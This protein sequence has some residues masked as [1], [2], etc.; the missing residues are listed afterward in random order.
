[1]SKVDLHMHTVFSD[2]TDT[3]EELFACV[4]EAGITCFAIT[5]H[6]SIKSSRFMTEY[7]SETASPSIN[8][9]AGVEFSCKDELGKYHILGY[10]YDPDGD[11]IHS[12]VDKGHQLRM[13]KLNERIRLLK[14]QYAVAFTEEEIATLQNL[15]NP[16]KPHLA[17]LM[18]RNG[19]APNKRVAFSKYL[20]KIHASSEYIRPE[21]AIEGIVR[22]GGIAVLAH[23]SLGSGDESIEGDELVARVLRLK[24]MG[25]CGVEAFYS[26][27]DENRT[28]E[29]LD[30]AKRHSLYVTAGSDYHGRNKNVKLGETGVLDPENIPA[31]MIRFLQDVRKL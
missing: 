27:F 29:L 12:I 15:E 24:E 19:Y 28:S 20:N 21:E 22:S 11:A 26:K 3:P 7:L 10:G 30:I 4:K 13:V 14:E 18:V 17:E 23:P 1:M 6:D 2:G 16:G 5:D 31:P 8:C 25:L 9:I